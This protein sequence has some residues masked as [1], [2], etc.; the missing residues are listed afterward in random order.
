MILRLQEP[1]PKRLLEI[2]PVSP[3]TPPTSGS[4]NFS[5]LGALL[6]SLD[7]REVEGLETLIW[8]TDNLKKCVVH[9]VK[10]SEQSRLILESKHLTQ[11]NP[12]AHSS[13]HWTRNPLILLCLSQPTGG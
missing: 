13:P 10:A 9:K 5:T 4:S 8:G 7:Q 12:L 2:K 6:G 3:D 11:H 1:R